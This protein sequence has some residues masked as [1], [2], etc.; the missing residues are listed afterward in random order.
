M[1]V[2]LD[3]GAQICFDKRLIKFVMD[4]SEIINNSAGSA[5]IEILGV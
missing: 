5:F 3:Y 4:F 1:F 2:F